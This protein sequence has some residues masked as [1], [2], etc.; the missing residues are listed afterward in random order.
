MEGYDRLVGSHRSGA[1]VEI[2]EQGRQRKPSKASD[3]PL[4][5]GVEVIFLNDAFCKQS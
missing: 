3:Y 5:V 1:S 4:L 2:K